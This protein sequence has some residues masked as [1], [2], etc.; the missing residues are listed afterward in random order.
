M[1]VYDSKRPAKCISYLEMNNFYGWGMSSC[2]PHD[3]F[4]WVKNVDGF[5]VALIGNQSQIEYI[6]EVNLEYPDELHILHND[7]SLAPDIL[8]VD[9][10]Y[11]DE[12][13]ILHN[14]YSLA[15]EKLAI[16]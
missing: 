6:L 1:K 16:P 14:N 4:K 15:P 9:L 8:E 7:Y 12:L 13:H 2:L 5:D 10:E 11:P 3:G